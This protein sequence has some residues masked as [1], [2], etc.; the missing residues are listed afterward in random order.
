MS[1]KNTKDPGFG[2]QSH[3]KVKSIIGK[4]GRSNV[5]HINRSFGLDDLYTFFIEMSWGKFFLLMIL[6]YLILN[7]IF[8]GLYW[9]VGI[10]HITQVS[11][12]EWTDFLNAFF[13][14]TQ[15]LTTLGY[16]ASFPSGKL[17][18]IIAS[19]EAFFG[20]LSFAFITGL[21]YARFSKPKAA[22]NFSKNMIL[23]PH[24]EGRALM[25]RLMN[26]RKTV[27]IEPEVNVTIS[28]N[29]KDDKGL[30]QRNFYRLQLEREKIM[31]LPT[32]WT[33]VHEIDEKSP[34]YTLSNQEIAN[35]NAELY[36]LAQYHEESYG[37]IVYQIG[38]Y[39]F[40]AIELEVKFSPAFEYNLD[41]FVVLDHHKLSDVEKMD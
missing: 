2:F 19:F 18:N 41:G 31:Y 33:V 34:L 12:N 3:E 36:I 14:S 30:F 38:T 27:M 6:G 20:L 23:R 15:T 4:N 32:V 11:G 29:K 25:F 21:L 39:H 1:A 13:F 17:A 40:S 28:I 5:Q 35:L 10:E 37:Q 22:I 7:I 26:S 8:G 9:F 16:G 24:K